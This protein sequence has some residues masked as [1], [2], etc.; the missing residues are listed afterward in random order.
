MIQGIAFDMDGLMFDTERLAKD[1]WAYAGSLLGIE[2][3]R[4]ASMKT[5]GLNAEGAMRVFKERFGENFNFQA[6]RKLRVDYVASYIEKNGVPIKEGLIEL[7][8]FLE[9]NRYRMTVAT[10]TERETAT[11]YL[12]KAGVADYFPAIVCGDMI[13]RGK[14]EPDIYLK[15]AET[16]G[17]APGDC[18]ALEDS[19]N[20][21][22]AAFRAGM[23]PVM[24]PDLVEPDG[25][26]ERL[27]FQKVKTLKD[28]I[29]LLQK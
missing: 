7:L 18:L 26:V 19:P 4:E 22:R 9:K 27:L 23:K 17:L 13:T 28:I 25:E 12:R 20:G 8:Q 16:M 11:N 14:P 2:G 15:A 29:K 21:I 3:A 1:G 10:S 24:I 6:A 5:I